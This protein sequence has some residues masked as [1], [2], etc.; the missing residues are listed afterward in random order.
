MSYVD[1]VTP[2]VEYAKQAAQ[3]DEQKSYEEALKLY[4]KSIEFFMTAIKHETK[5][6]KKKEML[7]E[8]VVE[9]LDRAEQI[10]KYLKN[11][12]EE[13]DGDH[14]SGASATKKKPSS[15]GDG[16]RGSKNNGYKNE[17][18]EE[19]GKLRG[20]LESKSHNVGC[21]ELLM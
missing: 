14:G 13:S 3:L 12:V 15:N 17:D 16:K 19:K 21:C 8:K 20:A 5:N 7:R 11:K 1:F 4:T 10:K 6:P 18:D 2:A 9:I